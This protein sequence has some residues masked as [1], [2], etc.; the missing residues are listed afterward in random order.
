MRCAG[1]GFCVLDVGEA[2][3]EWD[4]KEALRGCVEDKCRKRGH[5]ALRAWGGGGWVF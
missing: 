5:E 2:F 3:R 1:E 4:E